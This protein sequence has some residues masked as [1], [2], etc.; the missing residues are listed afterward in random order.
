[1]D[2]VYSLIWNHG[3]G[4]DDV[5]MLGDFQSD[6][7]TLGSILGPTKLMPVLAGDD[8][9]NTRLSEQ[10]AN[11]LVHSD[12]TSEFTGNA[13]TFRFM[14]RYNLSLQEALAISDHLPVWA[15]F[16]LEEK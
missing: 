2:E 11:I 16:E 9:T 6:S 3:N 13:D 5:I 12:A 10:A 14:R 1:M 7:S 8:F 15:E 4:E